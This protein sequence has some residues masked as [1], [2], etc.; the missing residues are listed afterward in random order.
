MRLRRY[1]R[2][3]TTFIATAAFGYLALVGVVFALQRNLLYFPDGQR[4]DLAEVGLAG[5]MVPVTLSTA[6]GLRLFAWH[7]AAQRADLPTFVYFHGN[8]GSIGHRAG[9]VRPYLDAGFG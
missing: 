8:G 1:L 6:D 3:M 4:P 5:I 2:K 7:R 9:K